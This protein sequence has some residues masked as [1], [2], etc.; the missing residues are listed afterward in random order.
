MSSVRLHD[1]RHDMET[2]SAP[3]ALWE[4]NPRPPVD[5]PHK[6]P[7][8]QRFDVPFDV[9]PSKLLNK[10]S[11]GRGFKMPW[12]SFH[13]HCNGWKLTVPQCMLKTNHQATHH[14]PFKLIVC[15][16]VCLVSFAPIYVPCY[17][18]R[19]FYQNYYCH[20]LTASFWMDIILTRTTTLMVNSVTLN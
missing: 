13:G 18:L 14:V 3:L 2:F 17:W 7:I 12:H 4:G 6:R 10:Q 20:L 19:L 9:G 1:M 11:H 15:L 5:F 16:V 8:R